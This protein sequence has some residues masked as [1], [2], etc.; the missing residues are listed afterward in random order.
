M[1]EQKIRTTWMW[2]D[3]Y[4][5]RGVSF[6]LESGRLQWYDVVGCHCTD[7][8]FLEQSLVAYSQNGPPPGIGLV[9]ADTAAEIDNTISYFLA[10]AQI[11]MS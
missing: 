10:T 9:P 1:F 2:L 7:E 4:D 11:E 6:D 5:V 8:E 3:G